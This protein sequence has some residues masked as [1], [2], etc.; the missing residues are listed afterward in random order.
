MS[1]KLPATKPLVTKPLVAK[2]LVT[3]LPIITADERLNTPR[4]ITG[5]I[6][7]K[8]GIGKTSL[9]WTLDPDSTLFID[10]EAGDL[11]VD[12]WQGNTIR[13]DSWPQCRDLACYIG[14]WN[15]AINNDRPYSKAH[16]D[17]VYHKYGTPEGFNGKYQT[18]FIDSITALSRICLDWC[19]GQPQCISEKTGKPDMR[20]V[21]GLMGQEMISWLTHLQHSRCFNIWF[22]GVLE[23]KQDDLGRT[24]FVPQIDGAKI[25]NELPAIVDQVITL[26]HIKDNDGNS[27]RAFINHTVNSYGSPVSGYPAKDRSGQLEMIEPPHLGKLMEK[28]KARAKTM[29]DKSQISANTKNITTNNDK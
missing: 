15:N 7:G 23:E 2:S 29:Q 25:A 26:A 17:A 4:Y 14:H 10:L 21:Y 19:K 24:I 20:A 6:F 16:C 5:C 22:V 11:A 28:I 18:I 8:Y 1:N 13:P 27:C 12:G 9:L 3:K